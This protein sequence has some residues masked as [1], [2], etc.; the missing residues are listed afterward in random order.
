M[1][2]PK[3]TMTVEELIKIWAHEKRT[4]EQITENL[5][6]H[7]KELKN[8]EE[9]LKIKGGPDIPLFEV[10]FATPDADA[11]TGEVQ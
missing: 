1:S 6:M 11:E 5:A 9:I 2:I 3:V 8:C 10:E 4:I 7:K